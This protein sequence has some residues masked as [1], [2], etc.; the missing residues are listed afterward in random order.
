MASFPAAQTM[1]DY[2]F[3][4]YLL[5]SHLGNEFHLISNHSQWLA[6]RSKYT[7]WTVILLIKYNSPKKEKYKTEK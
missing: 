4:I 2:F 6:I 3:N 7:K 5:N 1:I